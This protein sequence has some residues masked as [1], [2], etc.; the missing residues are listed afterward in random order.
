MIEKMQYYIDEYNIKAITPENYEQTMVVYESNQDFFITTEGSPA[1]KDGCLANI[2]SVPPGFDIINKYYIGFWK[3]E[4]CVAVMDFLLGYPNQDCVYIGLLLIHK[5]EQ[6][7]RL[8]RRIVEI[9]VWVSKNAGFKH[10]HLAVLSGNEKALSFW[11]RMG[12]EQA[13]QSTAVVQ[14]RDELAAIK[15]IYDIIVG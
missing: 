13:G 10:I 12:F 4:Q 1:T 9:L 5:K 8:G 3:K 7:K 6:Q 11:E 2:T 15:M 14:G